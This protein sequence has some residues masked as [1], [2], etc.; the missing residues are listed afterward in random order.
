[1]VH[2]LVLFGAAYIPL[3]TTC[4]LS[5]FYKAGRKEATVSYVDGGTGE[6]RARAIVIEGINQGGGDIGW[7]KEEPGWTDDRVSRCVFIDAIQPHRGSTVVC[8]AITV[9][10][11]VLSQLVSSETRTSVFHTKVLL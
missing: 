4:S 9:S 5:P 6:G 8:N 2:G 11:Q 3:C 7:L 10:C 1:M